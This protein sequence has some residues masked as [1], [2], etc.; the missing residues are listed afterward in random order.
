[1]RQPRSFNHLLGTV[2][3]ATDPWAQPT[4]DG[5]YHLV[6][7]QTSQGIFNG[8]RLL[9]PEYCLASGLCRLTNAIQFIGSDGTTTP[10]GWRQP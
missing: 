7:F 1:V 8:G 3:A 4:R 2:T 10:P 9:Q 5:G 6:S